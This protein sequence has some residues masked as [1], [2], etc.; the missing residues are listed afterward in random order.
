M[1]DNQYNVYV[2][3]SLSDAIVY[4]GIAKDV[5]IRLDEHNH[6]KSQFTKGNHLW[7]CYTLSL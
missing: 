4:V 3:R 2:I 5:Y 1:M 7:S 6:G